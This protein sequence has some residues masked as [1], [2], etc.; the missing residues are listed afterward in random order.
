[1]RKITYASALIVLAGF[2]PPLRAQAGVPLSPAQLQVLKADILADP[3]LSARPNTA[4]DAYAIAMAYNTTATPDFWVLRTSVREAEYTSMPSPDGTFWSWP[5]FIARSLQEQN[6]WTRMFMG[7]GAVNPSLPNV[8]QGFADIFSGTQNAAPAQ[9]AHLLACSRRK[10]TRAE[11]LFATG[12]GSTA[13]PATMGYEG[14]LTYID[15]Q[16]ARNLP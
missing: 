4:D 16:N 6:A 13:A 15:V 1:M 12:T 8:Q 14:S 9:R 2:V 11:K 5:A 10:A 7:T 3:V